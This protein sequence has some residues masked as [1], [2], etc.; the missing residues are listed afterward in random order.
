MRLGRSAR[1]PQ[2]LQIFQRGQIL[3]LEIHPLILCISTA[4]SALRV[5]TEYICVG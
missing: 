3:D 2:V 1:T 5:E 4:H